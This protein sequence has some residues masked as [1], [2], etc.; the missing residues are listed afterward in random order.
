L[1]FFRLLSP[2]IPSAS[3]AYTLIMPFFVQLLMSSFI[4]S[5]AYAYTGDA[6]FYHPETAFGVCGIKPQESDFVV[7]VASE[8]F[9]AYPGTTTSSFPICNKTLTA[10][11]Q[12]KTTQMKVID[13]CFTCVGEFG[14][15]L[16]VGA[17]SFFQ[18]NL[19]FG[20]LTGVEWSVE[21]D[22]GKREVGFEA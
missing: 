9:K 13:E 5:T 14:I 17:Y 4:V 21:G 7:S 6:T 11:Y 8:V 16:S 12:G 20:L 19:N 1:L 22:N 3:S 2:V 18:P 10:T 15:D